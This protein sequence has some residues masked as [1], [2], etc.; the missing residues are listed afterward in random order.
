LVDTATKPG[1]ICE[2]YNR[3]H[4]GTE[5]YAGLLTYLHVRPPKMFARWPGI[6]DVGWHFVVQRTRLDDAVPTWKKTYTSP[7]LT[8]T[9]TT[10]QAAQFSYVRVGVSVP[11]DGRWGVVQY[12]Y[13]VQVEMHWYGMHGSGGYVSA[14]SVHEVDVYSADLNGY[15]GGS[16]GMVF[17]DDCAGYVSYS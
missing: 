9:A 6:Q 15:P 5:L 17:D 3:T 2:Y 12:A 7:L 1:A 4:E 11:R 10:T 16:K 14:D 8:S 13:R